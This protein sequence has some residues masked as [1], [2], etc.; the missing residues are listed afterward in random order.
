M[1]YRVSRLWSICPLCAVLLTA[2]GTSLGADVALTRDGQTITKS[3][4]IKSGIHRVPDTADDGAILIKGDGITVDFQGAELLGCTDEQQPDQY[5]GKG[6]VLAGKNI[7]LKNAKVR[8]YKVGILAIGCPGLT[9]EDVDI[10]GN[11]QKHL[12]STPEAEDGSDWI[13]GHEND[14]DQWIK[15][16]GGGMYIKD[17]DGIT[18]RRVKARHGQNGILLSRVNNSKIYDND[19]SFISGWGLGL[20]RSSKNIITRNAFDFCVR[21]YS[22]GVYNRGQDSAGIFMFE[23]CCDN[24]LAENSVTHGGDGFFG[25]AGREALGEATPPSSDF[26]YKRR[27]NNNNLLIDNDF[28]YAPAHGIEMTFSFGNKFIRNRLVENAICGV[29]GGYCQ[30]TLIEGNLMEGN[31]QGAYGLERGG[32]NIDSGRN[33]WIVKNT[34]KNNACGVHLWGPANKAFVERAWGKANQPA[35][36]NTVIAFNTFDGDKLAIQL[37]GENE[38]SLESNTFKGVGKEVDASP[39]SKVEKHAHVRDF[40]T[41]KYEVYGQ[42]HP[43]GARKQLRGRQNIIMTEWGPYDFTDV[44][45]YPKRV[46]GSETATLR[47][48]GPSAGKFTVVKVDG[49]VKVS[50][51]G[52]ELPGKLTVTAPGPGF[53]PFTVEVEAGGKTL[54]AG[55]SLLWADWDVKFYK[56]TVADDPRDKPDRW[57]AIIEGTP[58]DQRKVTSIDFKWGSGALGPGLPADYFGTV[59]TTTMKLPAG[60]YK[61]ATVSDDGIRVWVDGKLVVDDWTWHPPKENDAEVSLAEGEHKIRIEHFEIDGMAQLQFSLEPAKK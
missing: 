44:L 27:G 50:P 5:T 48:L 15:N 23:Q 49:D 9:I 35:S 16:Y 45:L 54:K 17:S 43:V 18:I 51:T 56:W 61:V 6:L 12:L 31:G 11:Y 3:A 37:R 46:S 30:D 34:L 47:V 4:Q 19:C 7:T 36:V 2:A 8:G 10:S 24:V 38:V 39:K 29:W 53:H 60:K 1:Y 25:F 40:E 20:W 21:G 55:G 28:S 14:Q 42:T 57:K 41:P 13:F 52:G 58:I 32:V 33:N 26:D 22:H 59:A